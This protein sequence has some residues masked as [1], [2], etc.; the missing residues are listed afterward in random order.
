MN[1]LPSLGAIALLVIA[2]VVLLT[3]GS[4]GDGEPKST[5]AAEQNG[6]GGGPVVPVLDIVD[7][8]TIH[9][10][11]D[12]E[13]ESVRYIGIDTPEVDPSLGVEC[14]GHDASK[15]NARLVEGRDVRLVFDAERRDRYGRLLAYI[16]RRPDDLFVNAEMI[17]GGYARTLTI[18][19][20]DSFADALDRLEQA[21][22]NA[23]RGLWGEC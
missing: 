11:I 7:G 20:N 5:T 17:K 1:R 18:E 2:V 8:D 13:S 9:V 12:G 4:D 19:P 6:P 3:G 14:F 10:R 23:G 15:E 22:A 21:A 16:Y